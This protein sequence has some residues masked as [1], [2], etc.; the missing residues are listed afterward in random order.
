MNPVAEPSAV[1]PTTE[2][3][4]RVW[5]RPVG[6]SCKVRLEHADAARHLTGLLP[7]QLGDAVELQPTRPP[8]RIL[9]VPL[10]TRNCLARLEHVLKST[11]GVELM[12]DP[13]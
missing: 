7:D 4:I 13:A 3:P 9:L 12:L 2:A 1:A 10:H 5:L 11:P 6:A 8:G